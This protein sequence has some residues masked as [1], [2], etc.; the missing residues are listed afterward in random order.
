MPTTRTKATPTKQR[1]SKSTRPHPP[2]KKKAKT[3][4]EDARPL[5]RTSY[6]TQAMPKNILTTNLQQ[7]SLYES[8]HATPRSQGLNTNSL[9]PHPG[10][11]RK[12]RLVGLPYCLI[13]SLLPL[14][15]SRIYS[16]RASTS[17][18]RRL[19][20]YTTYS[21]LLTRV[22]TPPRRATMRRRRTTRTTRTLDAMGGG[23]HTQRMGVALTTINKL[24]TLVYTFFN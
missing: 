8:H 21:T 3:T 2:T 14:C 1:S 15:G 5:P 11:G 20:S 19:D 7:A 13:R 9:L 16:R 24:L 10:R 23:L 22:S 18:T 6:P 17:I 12:N 4:K